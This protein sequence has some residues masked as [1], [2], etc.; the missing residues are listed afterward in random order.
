M[1]ITR[2]PPRLERF[3]GFGNFDL[4]VCV[5]DSQ[6]SKVLR[7]AE[8]PQ[9]DQFEFKRIS[10]HAK[11]GKF[12]AAYAAF[13]DDVRALIREFAELKSTGRMT[14]S[15]LSSLLGTPNEEPNGD[16]RVEFPTRLKVVSKKRRSKHEVLG[17]GKETIGDSGSGG[18]G[19]RARPGPGGGEGEGEGEGKG[20]K[21]RKLRQ[22]SEP[23][24]EVGEKGKVHHIFFTVADAKDAESLN[25]FESGET[26]RNSIRFSL[27]ENGPL[28]GE[29]PK[30][31]W[32][33]VGTGKH[34]FRVDFFPTKPLASVE[35]WVAGEVE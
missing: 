24:L 35:A 20:E 8:N 23:L 33:V 1:L 4:F 26:G 29:V 19:A 13:A 11:R 3:P 32:A 22:A 16:Q 17:P 34:R 15:D 28:V 18:R 21:G 25:L 2:K 5:T 10:D 14:I 30:E 6:G 12:E 31:K 27:S 7:A 9:H